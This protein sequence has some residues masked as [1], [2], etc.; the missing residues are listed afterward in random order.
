M[1]ARAMPFGKH[2]GSRVDDLATDEPDYLRWVLEEVDMDRWPGLHD[3][4]REALHRRGELD[5]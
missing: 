2:K 4:I 5:E 1:D 3:Y